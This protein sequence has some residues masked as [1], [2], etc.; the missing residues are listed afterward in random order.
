MNDFPADYWHLLPDGKIECDLC[1]RSCKMKDGQRGKC[2]VRQRSGQSMIL[3][4]YGRSS[5]FCIDPVEKKPLNHFYPGS[6]ILSFGTAGCNLSCKFCQN[7]DIS[8]SKEF[9]RLTDQASPETIAQAALA[10]DCKSVALTYNDPVIFLEYGRD[11]AMACHEKDIRVVAVTN[12]YIWKEARKDFFSF[13][14]AANI[15]LKSFSNEFYKSLTGGDLKTVLDTLIYVRTQTKVWLELT[16]LIVPGEN[17]SPNEIKALSKWVFNELG[18][19][20]PLHFSAFHPDFKM[21]DR[22]A[23]P[24]ETLVM[25]RDIA[26]ETGLNYVYTGNVYYTPGDTTYCKSCGKALIERDWYN[27][28]AYRLDA[29]GDCINCGSHLAG[30]FD[31]THGHWGSKRKPIHL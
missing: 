27:L 9:D 13:V 30:C 12:G 15:D 23:T 2:F 10:N 17:D 20:T 18:A 5:G 29:N 19:D 14:D 28:S 16:T 11:A 22:S 1:P 7:W 26:M 25:A 3:T 24:L 8:R 31:V 4:T 21:R 6:P